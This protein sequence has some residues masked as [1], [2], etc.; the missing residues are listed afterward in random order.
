MAW[1]RRDL[2]SCKFYVQECNPFSTQTVT[3]KVVTDNVTFCNYRGK[4]CNRNMTK[5][6]MLFA[7]KICANL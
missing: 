2:T 1:L 5:F 4:W 3:N 7:L 6:E